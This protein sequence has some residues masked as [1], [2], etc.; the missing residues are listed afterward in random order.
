[1]VRKQCYPT[2]KQL[3]ALTYDQLFNLMLS[4]VMVHTG[5]KPTRE[6]L[7]AQFKHRLKFKQPIYKHVPYQTSN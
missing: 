2:F 6:S 3:K 7:L 5:V 4:T 1:M